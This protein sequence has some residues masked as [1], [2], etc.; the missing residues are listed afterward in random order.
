MQ[1]LAPIA[2][3]STESKVYEI[4]G[5]AELFPLYELRAKGLPPA[6]RNKGKG[7]AHNG[8]LTFHNGLE[9]GKPAP[10]MKTKTI[11]EEKN[12]KKKKRR[13]KFW[14]DYP[15]FPEIIIESV[16]FVAHDYPSWPPPLH[17]RIVFRQ[18]IS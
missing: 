16:E 18:L 12:G 2:I 6:K 8:V 15:D 1:D 3:E 4:K 5:R 9:D 10:K 7:A 17:R 11:E 14:P 13:I